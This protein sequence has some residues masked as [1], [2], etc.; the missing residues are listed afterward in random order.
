[1]GLLKVSGKALEWVG[2]VGNSTEEGWILNI[3]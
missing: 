3:R 2:Y 1:M